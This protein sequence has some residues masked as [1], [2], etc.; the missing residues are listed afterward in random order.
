ACEG[1][2]IESHLTEAERRWVTVNL[3]ANPSWRQKW[4]ALEEE[5]GKSV[6]WRAQALFPEPVVKPPSSLRAGAIG[7]IFNLLQPSW[8]F[9]FAVAAMIV[10]ALYGTLW[11]IG[12]ATLAE[13]HQ[14]AS[15]AQYQ[16]D[17]AAKIRGA[18][19]AASRDFSGGAA[20][21]LA[22]PKDWLGLFPRYDLA[23]IDEAM[24]HFQSAFENAPDPFQR[25]EI[26][27]FLAKACLMKN[28]ARQSK[29][30]LNQVL[31]QNVV[32]YREEAKALLQKLQ[33][34]N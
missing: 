18:S 26:A 28:D 21:L 32:D 20:A 10:L 13:T 1:K 11:L 9:R 31:A 19:T 17:L 5:L 29:H 33:E 30:W 25:A 16:D 14:L 22:A 3:D 8:P 24:T 12:R 6:D 2:G 7:E 4:Q 23:K 15:I 34:K 27:F